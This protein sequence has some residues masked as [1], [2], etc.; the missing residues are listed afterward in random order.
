ML[1]SSGLSPEAE[2]LALQLMDL[3]IAMGCP[4][5]LPLHYGWHCIDQLPAMAAQIAAQSVPRLQ[6][7]HS[8]PERQLQRRSPQL[9]G[10]DL[11]LPSPSTGI[12]SE[13]TC[14]E[15]RARSPAAPSSA[16]AL[17]RQSTDTSMDSQGMTLPATRAEC[18]PVEES[19]PHQATAC[20][21]LYSRASFEGRAGSLGEQQSLPAL[22]QR[23]PVQQQCA[24]EQPVASSANKGSPRCEGSA[25]EVQSG[26]GASMQR[27]A[28]PSPPQ[29]Q[30]GSD[31]SFASAKRCNTPR[32]QSRSNGQQAPATW[33]KDQAKMQLNTLA[34]P[35]ARAPKA[36]QG[37]VRRSRHALNRYREQHKTDVRAPAK[38]V[39][40]FF[41]L[42]RC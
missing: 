30:G 2:L 14:L 7:V 28:A 4:D 17:Q 34:V 20:A 32:E 3:C 21:G 35:V 24:A 23:P 16:E 36:G 37:K 9:G 29:G 42:M 1:S 38:P 41:N 10:K 6:T 40:S 11:P 15:Q 31:S 19:S 39:S 8:A 13:Q 33:S 25:Q 27:A 12:G 5:V 18:R 26:G 22:V